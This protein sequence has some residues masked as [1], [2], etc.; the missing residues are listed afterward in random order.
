MLIPF[1]V[2][3]A[4]CKKNKNRNVNQKFS[5]TKIDNLLVQRVDSQ[6]VKYHSQ[7]GDFIISITPDSFIGNLWNAR[8]FNETD[9]ED[10]GGYGQIVLIGPDANTPQGLTINFQRDSTINIS[11]KLIG[12]VYTNPDGT[13]GFFKEADVIFDMFYISMGFRMS[14]SLPSNYS[15]VQL[16]QFRNQGTEAS[17]SGMFL[18]T[19]QFPLTQAIPKLKTFGRNIDYYFGRVDS[20]YIGE[21]P[22]AVFG[23]SPCLRSKRYTTWTLEEPEPGHTNTIISTL[24]FNFDKI[25]HLY[26]GMDNIPYT[27]DDIVVF[28]PDFWERLYVQV[29]V[30]KE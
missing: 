4:A 2:L 24:G 9:V 21:K 17:Q 5:T 15:G 3:N 27:E 12:N 10:F 28:E 6:E 19:S 22:I 23:S 29:Q 25:V 30:I 26:A 16:K 14:I 13:G 1:L 8:Y 18:R 20:T 7:F 11:P